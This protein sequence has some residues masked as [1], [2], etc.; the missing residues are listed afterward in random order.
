MTMAMSAADGPFGSDNLDDPPF[1]PSTSSSNAHVRTNFGARRSY[2]PPDFPGTPPRL[3]PPVTNR[4]RQQS[5]M[6]APF[7]ERSPQPKPSVVR[8]NFVSADADRDVQSDAD[9]IPSTNSVDSYRQYHSD[10][11]DCSRISSPVDFA[12]RP[13]S[14]HTHPRASSSARCNTVSPERSE[15]NTSRALT[16]PTSNQEVPFVEAK[17]GKRHTP[18]DEAVISNCRP[19]EDYVEFGIADASITDVS[20]ANKEP[21]PD[22]LRKMAS[23]EDSIFDFET[24]EEELVGAT[25]GIQPA[26]S[27]KT[28]KNTTT[29]RGRRARR[30]IVEQTSMTDDDTSIENDYGEVPILPSGLQKRAQQAFSS[31]SKRTASPPSSPSRAVPS[32]AP[33]P[34]VVSPKVASPK[35]KKKTTVE[36]KEKGAVSFGEHKVYHFERDEVEDDSCSW[37]MASDYTKSIESEVEDAFKDLFF[38][39]RAKNHKPGRRRKTGEEDTMISSTIEEISIG[40]ETLD[41]RD[42]D[43]EETAVDTKSDTRS[44]ES[45]ALTKDSSTM[46][47]S[48]YATP[49]A[50]LGTT[51]ERSEKDCVEDPLLVVWNAVNGSVE[52]IKVAL[53]LASKPAKESKESSDVAPTDPPLSVTSLDSQ[54]E[55]ERPPPLQRV[56]SPTFESMLEFAQDVVK[57]STSLES[58]DTKGTRSTMSTV[59]EPEPAEPSPISIDE[60]KS[61]HNSILGAPS[62]EEASPSEAKIQLLEDD[63][64]LTDLA[65]HTCRSMH[66]LNGMVFDD[67]SEVNVITLVKFAYV[68]IGLPLGILFQEN[69]GGCWVAKIFENGNADK[70]TAS[71]GVNVGDQLAAINGVS[72]IEFKVDDICEMIAASDDKSEIELTFLRYDGPLRPLRVFHEEGY[73]IESDPNI[74]FGG[75][76]SGD[77]RD[78]EPAEPSTG[79]GEGL[80]PTRSSGQTR[81]SESESSFS[82]ASTKDTS[83]STLKSADKK[84]VF[85]SR[86]QNK[87]KRFKWFGR[88]KTT[89]KAKS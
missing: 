86:S 66:R 22:T 41:T 79:N 12:P 45:D 34:R 80:S 33:V 21:V 74:L 84:K 31:R 88:K 3:V 37:T 25:V 46:A 29:R 55:S 16:E 43:N 82:K 26:S 8:N 18:N 24:G 35:K 57:Q 56:N 68:K 1:V 10:T 69:G 67:T 62:A 23:E 59:D 83:V 38:I 87:G 9:F 15:A 20:L 63:P 70:V 13:A 28:K 61:D 39:G 85:S 89:A 60:S 42:E 65:L 11:D 40:D 54:D 64:R 76:T 81:E 32:D 75:V 58:S 2:M 73:E 44:L 77:Q 5:P 71:D 19:R 6:D 4:V 7:D 72:C 50:D 17:D 47:A 48:S 27:P 51:K 53:G 30:K 49:S 52:T 36:K 14:K 78:R